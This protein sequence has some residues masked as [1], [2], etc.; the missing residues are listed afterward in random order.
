MNKPPMPD[1]APMLPPYPDYPVPPPNVINMMQHGSH[2]P[3]YYNQTVVLQCLTSGVVSPVLIIR[4]V[5]HD[6]TVVGG[7]LQEGAKGVPDHFCAPGEVCGDPV[8]QLHKVA[9]EVYDPNMSAP[10]PGSPGPT[11][12]FLSC[13]V[14]KVNTYK[15]SSGRTWNHAETY[16]RSQSPAYPPPDSPGASSTGS[17][18]DYFSS[19]GSPV[20]SSGLDYLSSSQVPSS[21]G[22]RVGSSRRTAKR[23]NTNSSAPIVKTTSK[24]RKRV[25]SIGSDA[26]GSEYVSPSTRFGLSDQSMSSGALWSIDIGESAVWTIVGTGKYSKR[27]RVITTRGVLTISR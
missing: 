24:A 15:P 6:T 18:T 5:D 25:N 1:A 11:N 16:S 10:A 20:D 7:G 22:G 19:G 8:S 27:V 17:L 14:D 21:D 13:I 12:A 4:K 3:I 23:T 2:I 26:S 9:F